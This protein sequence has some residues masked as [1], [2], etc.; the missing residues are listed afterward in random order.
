MPH[1][2]HKLKSSHNADLPDA[3]AS[4]DWPPTLDEGKLYLHIMYEVKCTV[5]MLQ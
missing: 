2:I 5:E 4:T 3:Q 1:L